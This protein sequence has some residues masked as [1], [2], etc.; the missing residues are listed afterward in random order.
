MADLT[1]GALDKAPLRR[2]MRELRRSLLDRPE[3]SVSIWEHVRAL[4]AVRAASHFLV[5]ETIPGEPE[6]GPFLEWC[7]SNGR[8]VAMPD[9]E[10]DP[11]WPDVVLV[12]G[13]AFTPGGDRLGQGGGWYD[14][15]LAGVR[16]DCTTIG[17]GFDVQLVD[18]LPL[19][20][21]DVALD[22]VVTESGRASSRPAP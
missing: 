16:D 8:E 21:H 13:L 11:Q 7:R 17:V 5:F 9:D 4:P 10:A 18:E 6:I 3:R 1:R 2:S 19:E 14:R 15:F 22:C 20:P 12:P